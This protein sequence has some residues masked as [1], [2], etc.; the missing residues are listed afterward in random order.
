MRADHLAN[1]KKTARKLWRGLI[2]YILKGRDA[3]KKT[4]QSVGIRYRSHF[5][6]FY[7]YLKSVKILNL[8]FFFTTCNMGADLLVNSVFF[9]RFF[10][11]AAR[12]PLLFFGCSCSGIRI[13]R[14]VARLYDFTTLLALIFAFVWFIVK[15]TVNRYYRSPPLSAITVN[16]NRPCN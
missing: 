12:D 10:L 15:S 1:E 8:I 13:P 6:A 11:S 2:A 5:T 3:Q 4:S 7:I 14:A 16:H 9:F